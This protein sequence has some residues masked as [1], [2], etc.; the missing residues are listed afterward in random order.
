MCHLTRMGVYLTTAMSV[1]VPTITESGDVE[2][3]ALA[4]FLTR[5]V[6]VR[7]FHGTIKG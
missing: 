3:L 4:V 2:T 1:S 7:S 6:S 5:L